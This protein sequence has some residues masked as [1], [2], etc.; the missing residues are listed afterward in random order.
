MIICTF[1]EWR[2]QFRR[3]PKYQKPRNSGRVIPGNPKGR[4]L[5]K[6]IVPIIIFKGR[7]QAP[8]WVDEDKSATKP[9]TLNLKCLL[10]LDLFTILCIV[11]A[12]LSKVRKTV[13]YSKHI[14]GH[15][16]WVGYDV[17]LSF[18]ATEFKAHIA[19][20]EDVSRYISNIDEGA[21][22]NASLPRT[23]QGVEQR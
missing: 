14:Q 17:I 20:E 5:N 8:T 11:K 15:F 1:L 12:D 10:D 13:E 18:G 7:Q 21:C 2:I 16:F 4:N 23:K 22:L 3:T 9:T 19:W 6:V